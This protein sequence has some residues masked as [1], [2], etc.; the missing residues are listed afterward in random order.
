[1]HPLDMSGTHL[2]TPRLNEQDDVSA[3]QASSGNAAAQLEHQHSRYARFGHKRV[4]SRLFHCIL[5]AAAYSHFSATQPRVTCIYAPRVTTVMLCIWHPRC[6][7]RGQ[8]CTRFASCRILNLKLATKHGPATWKAHNARTEA[9]V[10]DCDRRLHAA[11]ARITD[12]NRKRKLRQEQARGDLERLQAEY[13]NL[14]KKNVSI[15]VACCALEAEVTALEAA[16]DGRSGGGGAAN[17]DGANDAAVENGAHAAPAAGAAQVEGAVLEPNNEAGQGAG[18][19]GALQ[20]RG[21]HGGGEVGAT[22]SG[23]ADDTVMQGD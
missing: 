7:C 21:A 2:D 12:T 4:R 11:E 8:R 14:L 3:W 17:A 18:A 19:L 20:V 13:T 16:R 5:Q 22:I 6:W 1:M 15:E 23:S 10:K 9:L